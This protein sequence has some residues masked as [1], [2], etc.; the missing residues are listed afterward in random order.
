MKTA[1]P[2]LALTALLALS[3]CSGSDS[4]CS[5]MPIFSGTTPRPESFRV[6]AEATFEVPAVQTQSC[7]DTAESQFPESVTATVYDP[8]NH[9]L[10]SEVML[11]HGGAIATVRF[12]PRTTGRHHVLVAFAPVG[13]VQQLG[14][15]VAGDW[16]GNNSAIVLP[17]P[18]CT[19]LDRTTRGTWLC[20][21]AALREPSGRVVRL[22]TSSIPPDV[23]VSGNVVWV[24]GE[25]RVR[26]FVDTG[27][28]LELTGSLLL[29]TAA[30]VRVVQSRLASEHELWVLDDQR[31]HR[32]TFS[33]TGVLAA[34]GATSWTAGDEAILGTDG[35]V[36]LLVRES[37]DRVLVVRMRQRPNSQ[38]CPYQ[39]GPDGA[40][41]PTGAPC[42]ALPGTPVGLEEG[43]VWTRVG[44]PFQATGQTL[45]RWVLSGGSL[46]EQGTLVLDSPA[47]AVDAA[48]RPG[49]VLPDIRLGM[50]AGATSVLPVG[51]SVQSPLGLERLPTSARAPRE[52][53]ALSP[54]FYWEGDTLQSNGSTKVYERPAG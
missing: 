28:E 9:I 39:L 6:G 33:D 51:S 54:R 11:R 53:R 24:V 12:T 41:A 45:H 31:L 36:G 30:P 2:L 7:D 13:S 48:L 3:G 29:G 10:P 17:L 18:R 1:R 44:E 23:A 34:A 32:F 43:V 8:G 19:Q 49:F 42:L 15:Y 37:L 14:A 16:S 27:T 5:A 40:F 4:P 35:V 38:A 20:D 25:G 46:A 50:L 21:G 47:D 52:L 22:G 26:R